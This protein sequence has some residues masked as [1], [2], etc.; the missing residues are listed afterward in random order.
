MEFMAIYVISYMTMLSLYFSFAY[1][2]LFDV[3]ENIAKI[4]FRTFVAGL[5]VWICFFTYYTYFGLDVSP[6]LHGY[7]EGI[8]DLFLVIWTFSFLVIFPMIVALEEYHDEDKIVF[9]IKIYCLIII[10]W[11]CIFSSR[12]HMLFN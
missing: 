8:S 4:T 10:V 1:M 12:L 3:S 7:L 5:I 6:F 2:F 11:C 9:M